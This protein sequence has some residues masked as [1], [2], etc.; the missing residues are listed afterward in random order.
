MC[1]FP[2][3]CDVST[4]ITP[5]GTERLN[6]LPRDTQ[7]ERQ[8]LEEARPSGPDLRLPFLPLLGSGQT[9][10]QPKSP[11]TWAQWGMFPLP[12]PVQNLGRWGG[13]GGGLGDAT[14]PLSPLCPWDSVPQTWGLK[15][16]PWIPTLVPPILGLV[17]PFLDLG[18][19]FPR[20]QS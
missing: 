11:V 1:L 15:G 20:G 14:C 5:H 3:L 19:S 7:P 9:S 12:V 16:T 18:L 17:E 2:A 10:H 6:K 13:R 4:V 8:G